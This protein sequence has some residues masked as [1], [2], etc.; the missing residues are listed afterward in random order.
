M[1]LKETLKSTLR[2]FASLP[3]VSRVL[4]DDDVRRVLERLP[5]SRAVY[6]GG[7]WQRRH[8]FDRDLGTDTSG[9]T[10]SQDLKAGGQHAALAHVTFY[11]GSQPSVL[12]TVLSSL[13]R[14][15]TS[16]FVDLGCGKG[17][18]LLVA[19]EFPFRDI[20]GVELSPALAEIARSNAALLAARYPQR[21]PIRV[22]LGDATEF[23]LP[24]GDLVLFLY[25]PF[26][27]ELVRKVAR[28]VEAAL[29]AEQRAIYV[30]LYN[31][32]N[33]ACF[34]ESSALIRRFARMLPYA[35]EELGYGP[36]TAD[37]VVVWQGGTA[38]APTG[39]ADAK[40]VVTQPG[41]RAELA[42]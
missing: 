2:T 34:D 18:P 11:G 6:G 22:E 16:T 10:S 17:R 24:S 7:G 28:A 33:G 39:P 12:R 32:V 14:P 41:I 30:V 40:I 8:P 19:S 27:T 5:G 3:G 23:P 31:P 13:P 1:M 36:D 21:T 29:A 42:A 35:P 20:V 9:I 25:H 15:E 37:A 26:G 38:P 4:F